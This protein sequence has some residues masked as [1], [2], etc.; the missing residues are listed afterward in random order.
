MKSKRLF[1]VLDDAVGDAPRVDLAEAAWARGVGMR[2]RRRVAFAA[3]GALLAA[4]VARAL[5]LRRLR[6]RSP[7]N[8]GRLQGP[9][10]CALGVEAT[11]V[12]HARMTRSGINGQ[13]SSRSSLISA[14]SS[15]AFPKFSPP[16]TSTG[17]VNCAES[18]RGP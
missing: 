5:V 13:L 14:S 6:F 16:P 11:G 17:Q 18:R 1:E 4:A 10:Q 2:R 7:D 15:V 8:R 9:R 12:I 3:G